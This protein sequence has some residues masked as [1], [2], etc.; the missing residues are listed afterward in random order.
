MVV[1]PTVDV[2]VVIPVEVVRVGK[3]RN[4]MIITMRTVAVVA[5]LVVQTRLLPIVDLE[6][7]S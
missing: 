5:A 7:V 4:T 3:V 2:P 6:A 1:V